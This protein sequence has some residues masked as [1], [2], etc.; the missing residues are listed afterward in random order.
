MR[1]SARGGL[2][3]AG[4][5]TSI[6]PVVLVVFLIVGQSAYWAGGTKWLA[7]ALDHDGTAIALNV[8]ELHTHASD[9]GSSPDRGAPTE[10]EHKLFHAM[11]HVQVLPSSL[12]PQRLR[13]D[14]TLIAVVVT[15]YLARSLAERKFRPP[16][17]RA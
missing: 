3:V 4:A 6:W 9:H 16:R 15:A 5:R 8:G 12:S 7:H 14:A 1:I 2:V 11:E 10:I 13:S 17:A